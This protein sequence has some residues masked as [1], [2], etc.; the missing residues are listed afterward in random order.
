[1]K[2]SLKCSGPVCN[3]NQAANQQR[4]LLVMGFFCL[5]V[6]GACSTTT[7]PDPFDSANLHQ[8]EFAQDDYAVDNSDGAT[9]ETA[10]SSQLADESEEITAFS[11]PVLNSL[12]FGDAAVQDGSVVA[13]MSSAGIFEIRRTAPSEYVVTLENTRVGSDVQRT[14]LAPPLSKGIKSVRVTEEGENTLLRVF[15]APEFDIQAQTFGS[16]IHLKALSQIEG[17][18]QSSNEGRAQFSEE[19]AVTETEG[20]DVVVE[21]SG[22]ELEGQLGNL[23]DGEPQ[24][25]GRLISLDLQ[26]TDIDNALRII[27]EV[28]NLNIISSQE[29]AGKVT[30]RLIDVPW[31]QALDVILKTNG[32]DK[33][34]EGNVI[35]IAPVERLRQE[36]E[37]LKQARQAEEELEPLQVKYVR[38]SYARAAELRTLVETIL[39][40]R[41]SVAVDE[42]TNQ[43]IIKD[44][45]RGVSNALELTKKLDLRTPQVLLETQ[46]VE[47]DR[48][49]GRELGSELSYQFAQ[50]PETGNATG[51]NFP[52]SILGSAS[53]SF[54]TAE[55]TLVNILLDSAD[56]TK[57]LAAAL[58]AAE[59]E[60]TARV[61]SR[62]AVVTTNNQTATIKSV[63][64][65]RVKT[66]SGGSSVS[67]GQGA[68]SQGAGGNA[69]ESFEVGIVLNVTPQASPDYFVLL[70]IDAKS[71]TLGSS[72]VDGIPSEVERSATST[73]LVS[74]GQTFAIGGIY[75]VDERTTLEGVPFLKDVPV[76]GTFFRRQI[77]QNSDEEL[78]FFITPRIVE[79]SFDDAAMRLNS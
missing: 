21:P 73:V 67:V 34:K 9:T 36:R 58:T 17:I 71:S 66:P 28:S 53:S 6:L 47:A 69:T 78:I 59:N 48:S 77:V 60:G 25:T 52:N 3:L 70:D 19:G 33:V 5:T 72:V 4:Q 43:L 31:D 41:G 50:S 39:S 2:T 27:A 18:Q 49:F 61:V 46:I 30:L 45:R 23:L 14:L 26:D 42:R 37:A 11:G 68:N 75:T 56:G 51:Y 44:I 57:S 24:Y 22:T 65:I 15:T 10:S 29:V 7:S 55:S 20:T 16:N 1:M 54:P 74:S 13:S 62:P 35:R 76:F 8:D 38:V 40:E 79:G 64:K 63:E 32:L 12:R